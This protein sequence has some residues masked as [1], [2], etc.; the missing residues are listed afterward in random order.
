[1]AASFERAGR[2]VRLSRDAGD[3]RN[4]ARALAVLGHACRERDEPRRARAFW[5]DAVAL[6]TD[7]GDPQAAK[8][9][10]ELAALAN[11]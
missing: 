3:R 10:A 1:M 5:L 9:T 2:A 7:L 11:R 8:I 6:F 4:E